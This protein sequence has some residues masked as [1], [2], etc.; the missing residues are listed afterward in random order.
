MKSAPGEVGDAR[1]RD[2]TL[3][4]VAGELPLRCNDDDQASRL[5]EEPPNGSQVLRLTGCLALGEP[6]DG[7]EARIGC[8]GYT[9]LLCWCMTTR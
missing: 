2:E 4:T 3:Q 5:L 1:L 7:N 6:R 9:F 8:C